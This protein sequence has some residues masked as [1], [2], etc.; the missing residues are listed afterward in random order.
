MPEHEW[1]E[2][3][4]KHCGANEQGYQATIAAGG[5]STCV[6]QGEG[7]PAAAEEMRPEPTRRIYASEDWDFINQRLGELQGERSAVPVSQWSQA[8][9]ERR[10]D[11]ILRHL[12]RWQGDHDHAGM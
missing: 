11:R 5:T 3:W 12:K 4:C 10:R 8:D 9:L 6:R 1:T 2:G 7:R